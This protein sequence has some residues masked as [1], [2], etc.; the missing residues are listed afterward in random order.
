MALVTCIE[1]GRTV[2]NLASACPNCGAP[3]QGRAAAAAV[4]QGVVTTEA[5]SKRLKLH[6]LG[7]GIL[8]I[9]GFAASIAAAYSGS[10][11]PSL[12]GGLSILIG[13]PWF[14]ITRFRIWWH[15]R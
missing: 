14:V 5:T 12:V 7:A 9:F 15:H 13:L 4:G 6:S 8:V 2:S 11:E 3:V 10:K 1:C